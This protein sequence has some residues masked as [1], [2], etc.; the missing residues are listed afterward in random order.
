[1]EE[2]PFYA[3][4]YLMITCAIFLGKAESQSS[5]KESHRSL[6]VCDPGKSRF[7][8]MGTRRYLVFDLTM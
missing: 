3:L 1:M 6:C 5:Q 2:G 4:I 7:I 8:K